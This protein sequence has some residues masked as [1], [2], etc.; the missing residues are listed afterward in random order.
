MPLVLYLLMYLR[1]RALDK[2]VMTDEEFKK[3]QFNKRVIKTYL[4]IFIII[5]GVGAASIMF[6]LWALVTS[7]ITLGQYIVL[8]LIGHTMSS[9]VTITGPV[10]ILRNRDVHDAWKER[11]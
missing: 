5:G 4:L 8:T 10:V 11:K 9:S 6:F 7:P 2:K 1:G 3:R